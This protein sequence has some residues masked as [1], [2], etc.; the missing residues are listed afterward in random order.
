M[1]AKPKVMV[2]DDV[3]IARRLMITGLSNC[4]DV[5]SASGGE[6]A[7]SMLPDVMPDA[8][9]LDV[10]MQP[11]ID[12]F[13]TCRRI[14][15][16][17]VFGLIPV[18]FVSARDALEDRL[19]GYEAGGED[20][21]VKPVVIAELEAKLQRLIERAIQKKQL[22]EM[23]SSASGAAMTAM[24]SMNELSALL[25]VIKRLGAVSN[26]VE[27]AD[28]LVSGLALYGLDG[29][30]QIRSGRDVITRCENGSAS[31]LEISVL[32]HLQGMGRLTQ[33]K[34]RM[35]INYPAA[36]LLVRNMPLDDEERCGRL[37]D[38]LTMMV[39]SA[40]TH[41]KELLAVAEAR[42]R[43]EAV[44][45]VAMRMAEALGEVDRAQRDSQVAMR[46]ALEGM[47]QRMDA[48]YVS[49]MLTSSQE[50][51]LTEA[52]DDGVEELLNSQGDIST[53]QDQLSQMVQEL[54]QAARLDLQ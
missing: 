48:A 21:V 29:C 12:G 22:N 27:V 9:L 44:L 37:R 5:V 28:A 15:S 13:E 2:V 42:A 50:R 45:Q 41:V 10:E 38:N 11:G 1:V 52:L 33:F 34:M 30:A 20:Y 6:E 53:L 36:S 40:E 7:L 49:T 17:P 43:D 31:P 46:I 25:E 8:I 18:I 51:M 35:V 3:A 26:L 54:R 16:N 24:V 19:S 14:R 23:V 47:R 4:F 32:E 39:E